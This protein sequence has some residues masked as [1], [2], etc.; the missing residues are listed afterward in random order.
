MKCP[1]CGFDVSETDLMPS[2]LTDSL[3]CCPNC[4]GKSKH[5]AVMGTDPA[6]VFAEAE[7]RSPKE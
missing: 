2:L 5:I 3:L 6:L 7:T 1:N 4:K